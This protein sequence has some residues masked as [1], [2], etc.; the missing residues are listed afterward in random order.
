MKCCRAIWLT[1]RA[2]KAFL[3]TEGDPLAGKEAILRGFEQIG[4]SLVWSRALRQLYETRIDWEGVRAK[5]ALLSDR[6]RASIDFIN[7]LADYVRPAFPEGR[8][9]GH[10]HISDLGRIR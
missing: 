9:P 4:P 1:F 10:A 2:A 7:G 8:H 5:R 6:C 3:A